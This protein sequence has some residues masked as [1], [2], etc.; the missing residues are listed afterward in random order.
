MKTRFILFFLLCFC[1]INFAS[2]QIGSPEVDNWILNQSGEI[3]IYIEHGTTGP[4]SVNILSTGD[5]ANVLEVCYDV[6]YVWIR[7]EGLADTMGLLATPNPPMAQGFVRKFP[8]TPVAATPGSESTT[9]GMIGLLLNGLA[10]DSRG[11]NS[12]YNGDGIWNGDIGV[13]EINALDDRFNAHAAMDNRYHT[14]AE[15]YYLDL[16]S[17]T[18]HSNLVG[19]AYD[20]HP[21]YGP[22]GYSDPMDST[23][24]ITRMISAYEL[25]NIMVRD[26]LPVPGGLL[27]PA[28]WGP[29]VDTTYPLGSF[30][31]DY[32]H[33]VIGAHLDEYNGRECRTPE[34]PDGTYAYFCTIDLAGTPIYPYMVGPTYHGVPEAVNI[35]PMANPTLPSSGCFNT[36]PLADQGPKGYQLGR[37]KL[38]PNPTSELLN[39]ELPS[40]E[41]GIV[42]VAVFDNLGRKVYQQSNESQ[43]QIVLDLQSYDKGI[44]YLKVSSN[45]K[46]HEAKVVVQ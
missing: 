41:Q 10:I 44:Y 15:P 18:E 20:G 42:D 28:D 17:N 32:D 30:S 34:Y 43:T 37:V 25:R 39:I 33:T 45:G 11:D 27:S 4:G 23:S 36:L 9:F 31:E 40:G 14:H 26:S 22:R 5:S 8:R 2:A 16:T 21:I 12:S 13:S 3:A 19:Y 1:S 24:A 29:P 6:D 35:G 38:F 7:A 46:T